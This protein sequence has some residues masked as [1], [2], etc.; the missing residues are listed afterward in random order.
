M[1]IAKFAAVGGI[2]F[3]IDAGIA[4]ALVAATEIGPY[5][6]R[7]ISFPAALTVT[8]YLNRVWTF[9]ATGVGR[10]RQ[11]GRYV[12]VQVLGNGVNLAVYALAIRLG[13]DWF[14]T[15]VIAPLAIASGVAMVANYLGARHWAYAKPAPCSATRACRR[16]SVE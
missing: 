12:A 11:Y 8:W 6:T 10:G 15:Y 4:Q 14:A 1:R 13:P 16:H 5:L 2:G 7:I 9:S 3:L